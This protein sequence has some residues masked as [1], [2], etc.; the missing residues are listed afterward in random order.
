MAALTVSGRRFHKARMLAPGLNAT[1]QSSR[2]R[3]QLQRHG[4]SLDINEEANHAPAT[5]WEGQIVRRASR[6]NEISLTSAPLKRSAARD[7]TSS[8]AERSWHETCCFNG[9]GSLCNEDRRWSS[10][11]ATTCGRG[12]AIR[13]G[14]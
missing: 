13:N 12:N 14:G 3:W 1:K 10:I 5:I 7:R 4:L 11:E 6:Q 9:E 2:L 8:K